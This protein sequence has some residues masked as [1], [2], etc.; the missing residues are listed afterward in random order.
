MTKISVIVPVYNAEPYLDKCIKSI[1]NQTLKDIQVLLINDCSTD[2][3]QSICEKYESMYESVE[4]INLE[5]NCGPQIARNKGL[6]LAKGEYIVFIDADDSIDYQM[7]EV[8]YNRAMINHPDILMYNVID[9]IEGKGK[10][11]FKDGLYERKDIERTFFPKLIGYIDENGWINVTRWCI[12]LRMFNRDFIIKNN[13]KFDDRF[14]RCQDLQFTVISTIAAKK[15]EYYGDGY[16]Y[17]QIIHK[18][19]LSRGYNKDLFDLLKPLMTT[20]KEIS[21]EYKSYDF[22]GQVAIRNLQFILMSINNERKESGKTREEAEKEIQRIIND[23]ITKTC[24]EDMKDI[25][26]I[27]YESVIKQIENND[28]AALY[29]HSADYSYRHIRFYRILHQYFGYHI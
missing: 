1:V 25:K 6:E 2:N 15:I 12:W 13:I 29:D 17:N 20:L 9:N 5:K 3:S 28:V 18:D 4:L 7:C 19:S 8:L 21:K 10:K 24:I 11:F 27:R 26:K 23:P 16:L 14:R 22:S